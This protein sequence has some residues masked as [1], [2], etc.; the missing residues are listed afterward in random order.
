LLAIAESKM[1]N[2]YNTKRGSIK[3]NILIGSPVGVITAAKTAIATIATRQLLSNNFGLTIPTF[4]RTK[5]T[6]GN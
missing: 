1:L 2:K 3:I 4:V 5:N 6:N